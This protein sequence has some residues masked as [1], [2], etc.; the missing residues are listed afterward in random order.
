MSAIAYRG[1]A[2]VGTHTAPSTIVVEDGI[3]RSIE[4]SLVSNGNLPD[5]VIDA[6]LISP[7]LID[8]Q[9]NGAYGAEV[10]PNP[11][12]IDLISERFLE[13][14]VT[15]WLPTVVTSA[16]AAY[17]PFFEAWSKHNPNAGA[18]PLGYHLEGPFLTL[19][20]KGAHNP[21]F[22]LA[23]SE[24]LFQSWLQQD[25]ITLVTLSPER[26]GNLERIR[27]MVDAG[28]LV[29]L[30]HTNATFE[31]FIAG[32][33]AGARKA[34]HLFNAM[35]AIHHR[36]PGA[37]VATLVDDR[38]TAGLIPDGV[39]SHQATVRLAIKAKGFDNIVI[40][41][42]MMAACGLGPGTYPL[43]TMNVIVDESSARLADGTLAGSILTMDQALRNLVEWSECTPAQAI[44][45]MT[46]VPARLL[47]DTTRGRLVIGARAD[48]A[49][50]NRD[51][52]PTSTM[53]GGEIKWQAAE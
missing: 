14:G 26:D 24:E 37:M 39:H 12:D 53:V 40:V 25:S 6:D 47:E 8:L 33:D 16:A 50:W 11:A 42:D 44:H 19:E 2:V 46:A 4:R 3:I 52:Q 22:I 1:N 23:A 30:G 28:I 43:G 34:T 21:D 51:L 10:T 35:S 29:S 41:S 27:Q 32:L 36:A 49:T 45:M 20:K 5:I 38:V 18:V 31:E 17:P 9:V 48:I 15:A 13:T 7:G